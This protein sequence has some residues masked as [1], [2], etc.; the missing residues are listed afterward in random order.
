LK[1]N[2][3]AS[4]D[5]INPIDRLK[6]N[7]VLFQREIGAYTRLRFTLDPIAE[8]LG[9]FAYAEECGA[10]Q[11]S[12]NRIFESSSAV[13]GF[14]IALKL[15]QQAYSGEMGWTLDS[16]GVVDCKHSIPNVPMRK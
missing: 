4:F 8:F 2:G 3:W 14:Q 15:I 12:W 13:P 6:S 11:D 16:N 5:R 10:N 1:N 9:A 7:G